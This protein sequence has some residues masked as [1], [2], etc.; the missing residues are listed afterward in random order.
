[1]A[2][3]RHLIALS[4]LLVTSIAYTQV[5]EKATNL[6]ILL[7][8]FYTEVTNK[9]SLI[10]LKLSKEVDNLLLI[11]NNL[12]TKS[13]ALYN[14]AKGYVYYLNKLNPETFLIKADSLNN[15]L[16]DPDI[17]VKVYSSYVLGE[18]YYDNKEDLKARKAYSKIIEIDNIPKKF[19]HYKSEALDRV[20]F[21]DRTF[22]STKI[23]D[24][25]E[26]KNTAKRLI[27]FKKALNDTLNN[28]YGKAL[29]YLNFKQKAEN[30]FLSIS[31]IPKGDV[32][33]NKYTKFQALNWLSLY[34]YKNINYN[35]NDTINA[36]KLI[37]TSEELLSTVKNTD[38]LELHNIYSIYGNIIASSVITKDQKRI[39]LYEEKILKL[40]NRP[41]FP[42]NEKINLNQFYYTIHKLKMFFEYGKN[43]EKAKFYAYKNV[44]LTKFVYGDISVEH[45]QE[46]LSYQNILKLR[47]FQYEKAFNVSVQRGEII[48]K[49]YG[50][51]T[52]KYLEVLSLQYNIRLS[53]S[54]FKKGL[55]IMGKALSI[56]KET[57]C[58]N[59]NI[60]ND[61]KLNY[62]HCLNYNELFKET[63]QKT[64]SITFK[65]D[66]KTILD[67][68]NIKRYA[69]LGLKNYKDLNIEYENTLSKF[70]S[71]KK[72][73]FED[74]YIIIEIKSFLQ[75][76]QKYLNDLGRLEK[77]KYLY[78]DY[79]YLFEK[80]G[81]NLRKAEF[82]LGY[83]ETL[84]LNNKC[85]EALKFYEENEILTFDNITTPEAK[86]LYK[87][88]LNYQLGIIYES[89]GDYKKGIDFFKEA[90]EHHLFKTQVYI[91]LSR[92]YR[93]TDD[94][95]KSSIYLEKLL[96]IIESKENIDIPTLFLIVDNYVL[97]NN[98]AKAVEY[99][100]PLSYKIIDQICEK[101]FFSFGDNDLDILTHNDFIGMV[102]T[103]NHGD[104]YNAELAGNIVTI[105][106]LYKRRL[107]VY[108]QINLGIQRLKDSKN[109]VAIKLLNI[110]N[111]F[112]SKPTEALAEEIRQLK[113]KIISSELFEYDDLCDINYR[114]I[115]NS[116]NENELVIN[117]ISFYDDVD[118]SENFAINF[119]SKD[120]SL[121]TT[122]VHL[123]DHIRLDL[124]K[125]INSQFFDY[126]SKEILKNEKINGDLIN[127]IYI[128]PS[129][130]S[131][132]INFSAFS[133]HLEEKINKKLNIYTINSLTSITKL[134]QQ[135][136]KKV[137]NII[138]LGDIDYDKK[139]KLNSINN[140]KQT[141]GIELNSSIKNSGIP[142]WSYLPGTKKEI[143]E[144]EHLAYKNN[145][146]VTVLS[147]KDVTEQNIKKIIIEPNKN[148]I[149]HIATHGY[150]FPDNIDTN[151][152]NLFANHKNT[153]LRS[154]L[155]LS[156]ANNNWNNKKLIDSN[157]DGILTAEEISFI[158][159]KGV[160]LVVLSA[161]D[162]GLG[163]VSKLEGINGLQRAFKLA[164]ANKLIMSLWKIPDNETSEFFGYFYNFLL[165]EKLSVNLSFRKTQKIM[166]EKYE[167]YYWAG[168]VLL[169]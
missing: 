53:Q 112:N 143:E 157:N 153:L 78:K 127:T 121:M 91:S 120:V 69:L 59:S 115:F 167:P 58:E 162:T 119:S 156:G 82:M 150:F 47:L 71:E 72:L 61:I 51:K 45:E 64:K 130:T 109:N 117:L 15:L 7:N 23:K 60:C 159:L 73:L 118:K 129:G 100:L 145:I 125:D 24:S 41:S 3:T 169:E 107:D 37:K 116:I 144:I 99:S 5:K 140:L 97:K 62:L 154:G 141:R 17:N 88:K 25:L 94:E 155:I 36:H 123:K 113:T 110:E 54:D 106:N 101:S 90:E 160:E 105:S 103:V 147:D 63:L 33:Y 132:L 21:I 124:K 68:S 65:N 42:I 102:L 56:I 165:K 92:L 26:A 81:T 29:S 52:L 76:Y 1:M 66:L 57:N 35:I 164:G 135:Q 50:V 14:N 49:L 111:K 77:A 87:S 80:S 139:T 9:N 136:N 31:S 152:K 131:H 95:K 83:L 75:D 4:I 85:N 133:H 104:I 142:L 48:K 108:S 74:N 149:I 137:E 114:D 67:L 2:R 70:N 34:Y 166:K 20:F 27:I 13:L 122:K 79:Y 19:Y 39:D 151:T 32:R 138:L 44:A 128:I 93:F 86:F 12:N 98:R 28:G 10:P 46:L 6:N 38:Y 126:V 89:L 8:E 163:N 30:V 16:E 168:F 43:Y 148:N 84:F 161:C 55:N 96:R 22:V 11:K 146:D 18:F 40:V 134:K 158:D